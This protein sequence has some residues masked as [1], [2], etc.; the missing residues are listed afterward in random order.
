VW[1]LLA[2][3]ELSK[4]LARVELLPLKLA[5][6]VME[7]KVFASFAFMF[8]GNAAVVVAPAAAEVVES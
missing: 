5:W 4:L 8:A 7:L 3:P 6:L 2:P 1:G